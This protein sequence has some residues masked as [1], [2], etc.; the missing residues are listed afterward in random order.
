MDICPYTANPDQGNEDACLDDFDGDGI[1]NVDDN[2]Q[3][4]ANPG[5]ETHDGEQGVACNIPV[6]G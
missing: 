4:V 3:E 2:C 5:Q 1:L 6:G